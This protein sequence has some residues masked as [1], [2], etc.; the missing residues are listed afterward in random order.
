M[1]RWSINF[2]EL[3]QGFFIYNSTYP[4]IWADYN[5]TNLD[6]EYLGMKFIGTIEPAIV[7]NL[8]ENIKDNRIIKVKLNESIF[9]EYNDLTQGFFIYHPR[10]TPCD[11]TQF[12]VENDT[13][14]FELDAETDYSIDNDD[15]I[16]FNYKNYFPFSGKDRYA[17]TILATFGG[18]IHQIILIVEYIISPLNC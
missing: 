12:F 4:Q 8:N 3:E 18:I 11:L 14:I 16:V 9:V 7:D 6:R 2:N 15:F 17:P 10:L 5:S 13:T 1:R